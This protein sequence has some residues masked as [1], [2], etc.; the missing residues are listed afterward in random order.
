MPLTRAD[1]E[2]VDGY[3]QSHQP[4]LAKLILE[5]HLKEEPFDETAR[6][7]LNKINT[8]YPGSPTPPAAAAAAQTPPPRPT[9]PA[10]VVKPKKDLPPPTSLIDADENDI[11]LIKQ[12]IKE[13]QYDKADALLV[14]S[15]HPDAERLRER[16]AALRVSGGGQKAK[17]AHDEAAPDLTGKLSL[18][19]FLLIFLTLFGLIALAIWLPEAKRYPDAPGA[20]GF[21]MTNKVVTWI[22][23]GLLV[24]LVLFI[25]ALLLTM[26]TPPV[27]R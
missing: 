16:L 26:Q 2:Q 5:R 21:L 3:L 4:H 15:D 20:Q 19:I 24:L 7:A 14:L 10:P 25:G 8:R 23:R 17:R 13:Q 18:T 1:R 11:A 9:T 6:K 22:L 12:L 27:R